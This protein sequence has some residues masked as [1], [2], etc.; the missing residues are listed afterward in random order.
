M[1]PVEL[2]GRS[3]WRSS[4]ETLKGF[5]DCRKEFR[6]VLVVRSHQIPKQRRVNCIPSLVEAIGIK[7]WRSNLTA[8]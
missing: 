2:S 7:Q 5:G 1:E 6:F 3:G 4:L 8:Y